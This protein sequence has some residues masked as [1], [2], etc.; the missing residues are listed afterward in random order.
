MSIKC[1][2]MNNCTFGYVWLR[3]CVA[4]RAPRRDEL[5][6]HAFF[7]FFGSSPGSTMRML[8]T[9]RSTCETITM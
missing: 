9:H 4:L 3:L 5:V 6:N 7:F 1:Y 2:G 8:N